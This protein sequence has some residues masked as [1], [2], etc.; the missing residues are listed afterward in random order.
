MPAP[1]KAPPI[2]HQP[3]GETWLALS[4]AILAAPSIPAICSELT[5]CCV[6][7]FGGEWVSVYLVDNERRQ[8]LL[9]AH[10]GA[11][12]RS[13]VSYDELC[14]DLGASVLTD[15]Q[16]RL[17]SGAKRIVAAL[18]SRGKILGAVSVSGAQEYSSQDLPR[19]AWLAVQ[20]AAALEITQL[21]QAEADRRKVAE[22]LVQAGRNLV[23]QVKP[24]EVPERILELLEAVV[25][26]ERGS[27]MMREGDSLKIAAHRGFPPDER[28]EQL[29]VVL[30]EGDVFQRA[31]QSARLVIV[32]DVTQ[33]PG[34]QQVDWLPLNLSWMGVPL[35]LQD[36]TMGMISLTRREAQAFSEDDAVLAST[37]ALQA[38]VALENAALYEEIT[39]FN[40]HLE[41]MV[42]QRTEELKRAYQTL[43]KLDQNKSDFIDVAAHELRT[44]LTIMK[45]YLGMMSADPGLKGN[46]YLLSALDGL[47]KGTDRL[48]E[49]VNSML[50]VARIDS[51]VLDLR[52][53]PTAIGPILKRV[54]RDFEADL[55]QRSLTFELVGLEML[56]LVNADA[57]LLLKV[58]QNLV[59]NAMKYT[60]DGGKITLSALTLRDE[61]LGDCIEIRVQD[62][63]I[64]I[65]PEH[66]ELVFEKFYRTEP[67][68]LHSSGKTKFKGGGPG[69]GLAIVRGIVLA[70]GGRIWVESP[71]RDEADCP[72]SCFHVLLPIGEYPQ[73]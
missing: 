10:N 25:P 55:Q 71:R 14:A 35:F 57:T 64:G 59:G 44:P 62:T 70:H 72:G 56:P 65:A 67:A 28:V 50:D 1:Q 24:R 58:F 21:R 18:I 5:Q 32:D 3:Q 61:A 13:G 30:R 38:A 6:Q 52:A 53:E 73:S 27:L 29:R 69:L 40:Q 20:A 60:P 37:F 8:V 19:L 68:A 39:N 42:Q 45:G 49:I 48:H 47:L 2:T 41:Q 43:E 54:W 22:Q 63:G 34:W 51:Q 31:T 11:V 12:T 26:Y 17:H 4:Q 16:P 46:A 7:Q 33:T 23:G 36:R 9:A 66:Q 15:G